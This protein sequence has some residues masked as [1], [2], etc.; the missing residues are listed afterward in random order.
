MGGV[1]L[2]KYSQNFKSL[3]L[4]LNVIKIV[5]NHYFQK[6]LDFDEKYTILE[7]IF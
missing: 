7:Q 4:I 1:E 5:K 6:I 2:A 3:A